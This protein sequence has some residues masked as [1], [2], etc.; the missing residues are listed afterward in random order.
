M[1]VFQNNHQEEIIMKITLHTIK[2]RDLV[3]GYE[4][5]DDAMDRLHDLCDSLYKRNHGYYDDGILFLCDKEWVYICSFGYCAEK[6]SERRADSI[7]K[8]GNDAGIIGAAF[9]GKAI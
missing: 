2:V 7:A 5:N 6:M 1:P 4:D 9:L 8:L 3:S